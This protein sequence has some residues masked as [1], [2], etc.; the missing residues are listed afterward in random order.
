MSKKASTADTKE[1][2]LA[3]KPAPPKRP[4]GPQ[5][6]VFKFR[7]KDKSYQMTY[8]QAFTYAHRLFTKKQYGLAAAIFEKLTKAPDRGPRA[9]IMQA[10]CLAADSNYDG[11]R[12]VLNSA[13]AGDEVVI[14]GQL[15]DIIVMARLGLP[16]DALQDLVTMV[17]QHKELPTLCLWLGDMLAASQDFKKARQCWKLAIHRDRPGGAV[18]L[19][20]RELLQG[21]KSA[22]SKRPPGGAKTP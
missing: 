6:A 15:Q 10:I 17:N 18:A 3:P 20:A 5:R 2:V 11:S 12:E 22:R 16:G 7:V 19:A 8:Q 14:A 1:L 4:P 9:H 13:F 21:G